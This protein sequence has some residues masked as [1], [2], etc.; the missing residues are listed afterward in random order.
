MSAVVLLG[1]ADTRRTIYLQRAAAETGISFTLM[2][3]RKLPEGWP[4]REAQHQLFVKIDPP[5]W[6][7]CRLGELGELTANYRRALAE[8]EYFAG[9]RQTDFLNTPAAIAA[10][11]DKRT[12]KHMLKTA[13]LPVTEMLDGEFK[14]AGALLEGMKTRGWH[15][16]FIKPV[17]G[18]GAAG[19]S[20]LRIRQGGDRMALYTCAAMDAAQGI[21]NT[22]RLRHLEDPGEILPLLEEILRLD[23]IVE[24]WYAKAAYRDCCYDLRAVVQDGHMDYLLAR[25]S[26]GPITNL[27]LNNRPLDIA[28]LGLADTMPKVLE[29]ICNRAM[30]CFPGL[31]SAG[32]DLLLER[33]SLRPRIIEMNGQGDL[34]YQDI[35]H[36]NRIYRHQAQMMKRWMQA[37]DGAVT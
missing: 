30:A 19:V 33:D 7:S 36:E 10:L 11:L 28:R 32:I 35:F 18:S 23:C 21:V 27:Q 20:A 6:G 34:L 22:K 37:E 26:K 5:L 2:D 9:Q 16:V 14:E 3:W 1:S 25:L 12:C 29:D 17:Y 31:R 8:L 24:R 4:G 13:G 15:Q